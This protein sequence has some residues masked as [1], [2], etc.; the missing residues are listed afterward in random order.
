MH[1]LEAAS[2][3]SLSKLRKV[4]RPALAGAFP[5]AVASVATATVGLASGLATGLATNLTAPLQTDIQ[6]LEYQFR[7]NRTSL[8][9]AD[10]RRLALHYATDSATSAIVFA[11]PHDPY[12]DVEPAKPDSSL[13]QFEELPIAKAYNYMKEAL[14]L[15]ATDMYRLLICYEFQLCDSLERTIAA[16]ECDNKGMNSE[17]DMAMYREAMSRIHD[18]RSRLTRTQ[19][20]LRR[21]LRE[22]KNAS[23]EALMMEAQLCLAGFA[24]S[25]VP[26]VAGEDG[27]DAIEPLDAAIEVLEAACNNKRLP[28]RYQAKLWLADLYERRSCPAGAGA[29]P[30]ASVRRHQLLVEC[31]EQIDD[32]VIQREATKR[33][34]KY[35]ADLAPFMTTVDPPYD[36]PMALRCCQ[37]ATTYFNGNLAC[38]LEFVSVVLGA[39]DCG[40]LGGDEYKMQHRLVMGHV[41]HLAGLF[42]ERGNMVEANAALCQLGKLAEVDPALPDDRLRAAKAL[43][44]YEKAAADD[45][46]DQEALGRL[47]IAVIGRQQ[48]VLP[49]TAR[50]VALVS[51]RCSTHWTGRVHGFQVSVNAEE[52]MTSQPVVDD[53]HRRPTGDDIH[54]PS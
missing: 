25:V 15:G 45:H 5:S 52:G 14:A 2:Q 34:A 21:W 4:A 8:T 48:V 37:E 51:T 54:P 26:A 7:T 22:W 24:A 11:L 40:L 17:T 28:S 50:T 23:P 16:Q 32:P 29:D 3:W 33:L 47:V 1:S 38:A 35:F 39:H 6:R 20:I 42:R 9:V 13:A 44:Y 10:Y 18:M 31:T 53:M 36:L 41:R 30:A 19:Q 12:D 49:V 43:T 46:P 27:A